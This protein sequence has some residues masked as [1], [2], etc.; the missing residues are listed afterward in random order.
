LQQNFF[1]DYLALDFFV[2]AAKQYCGVQPYGK[3]VTLT[4]INQPC[5]NHPPFYEFVQVR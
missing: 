3:H 5:A 2:T 1:S 4:E